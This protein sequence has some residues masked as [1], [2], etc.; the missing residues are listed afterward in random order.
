MVMTNQPNTELDQQPEQQSLTSLPNENSKLTDYV[1]KFKQQKSV[2]HEARISAFFSDIK[3]K[4][5]SIQIV[6]LSVDKLDEAFTYALLHFP[7]DCLL[8]E[9]EAIKLEMDLKKVLI[10]CS[11]IC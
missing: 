5:H 7:L 1:I 10:L 11:L 3:N 6:Y 4:C 2:E 9:A 8:D